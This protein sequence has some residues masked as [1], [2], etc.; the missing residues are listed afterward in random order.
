MEESLERSNDPIGCVAARFEERWVP[1]QDGVELRLLLWS[2]VEGADA[3]PVIFV[4][5]LISVVE[6]WRPLLEE[7]LPRRPVIYIE[8][9]EKK[10]ARIECRRMLPEE[11][12][13]PRLAEDLIEVAAALQLNSDRGVWFGSSMGSNA[14]IEALKHDR[15]PARTA[16][17]VGPNAAFAVPWWGHPLLYSPPSLYHAIRPFLLWYIRHFR[18]DAEAEPEQMERYVRTLTAADPL[19]LKLSAR[20]VVGYEVWPE[21]EAIGTPVAIAYAPTDTLHGEEEV[22]AILKRMP[23]GVG[24]ECPTNTYM[25][26]AAVAQDIERFERS[27]D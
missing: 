3:D 14:I 26:E 7:L 17:L 20:G 27:L 21:L 12:S 13:M 8:T 2:P 9:R 1:V 16:F 4:P 5:G 23:C 25:H 18:V 24:V 11:F 15:L 22:K 19:R 10:S 6:G